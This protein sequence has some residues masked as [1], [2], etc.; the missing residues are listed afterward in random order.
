M[1]SFEITYKDVIEA[2]NEEEAIVW[3][4]QYLTDCLN[5]EDVS[6]FMFNEVKENE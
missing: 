3:L 4:F 1:P 2:E 5:D 6:V